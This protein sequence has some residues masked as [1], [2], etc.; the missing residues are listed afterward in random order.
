MCHFRLA[1]ENFQLG[2]QRE[3]I[4]VVNPLSLTSTSAEWPP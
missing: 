2:L 4:D 1:S 3:Y